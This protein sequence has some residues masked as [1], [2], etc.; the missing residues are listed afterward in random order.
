MKNETADRAER[1]GLL[2][3]IFFASLAAC[4]QTFLLLHLRLN[5]LPIFLSAVLLL[6]FARKLSRR[7]L[8]DLAALF[9]GLWALGTLCSKVYDLSWDGQTYH[10]EAVFQLAHGWNPIW[11]A[12]LPL[13]HRD[14]QWIN[15][16]PK[17]TWIIGA[18]IYLSR[19]QI[20]SA[21]L[22]S[23]SLMIA[24]LLLGYAACRA[25]SLKRAMSGLIATL[26]ALCPVV[27]CQLPSFYVDGV[28]G[29]LLTILLS[30]A[31]LYVKQPRGRYLLAM[32]AALG[33][34][35]V[36][37]FTGIGYA[38]IY[39]FCLIL[40]VLLRLRSRLRAVLITQTVGIVFGVLFL[41]F[42]PYV[43]NLAAGRHPFHPLAGKH[44]IDLMAEQLGPAFTAQPRLVMLTES[45]FAESSNDR[46]WPRWKIPF[47]VTQQE[48]HEFVIPD[49]RIG[50]FG[51]WFG[52]VLLLSGIGLLTLFVTQLRN[53]KLPSSRREKR[54]RV[55]D[56][57]LIGS[58]VLLGIFGSCLINPALWWARYVPQ[59]WLIPVIVLLL[60]RIHR[61]RFL[62][63]LLFALLGNLGLVLVPS[64]YLHD[65]EQRYVRTEL[66]NYRN[67][68]L[69]VDFHAFYGTRF[70]LWNAQVSYRET[71]ALRCATPYV[72]GRSA[73]AFCVQA[74][75]P[76][77]P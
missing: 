23:P 60:L 25:L 13:W 66:H 49:V 59:L 24:A 68:K 16:Y 77:S 67:T 46:Q 14:I 65:K 33:M 5:R 28:L 69:D 18:M 55:P 58:V 53:P 8:F 64:L 38:G 20:E 9:A 37:K 75:E 10:Q 19:K 61:S 4:G 54:R 76:S 74:Q 12:P 56:S 3:L 48:L 15:S 63:P 43:T 2:L 11:D 27:L 71:A 42:Q 26:A 34:L 6:L 52:A 21:K 45:V 44:K 62:W 22:L 50:G 39:A 41:G 47:A 17:G 40:F 30:L 72:F 1:F 57:L 51:P 29:S 35:C 31:V 36:V 73:A 7:P 32:I 70:R